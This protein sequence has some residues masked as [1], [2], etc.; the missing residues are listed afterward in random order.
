M[1]KIK[2]A[3]NPISSQLLIGKNTLAQETKIPF[4]KNVIIC[5]ILILLPL[6][7]AMFIYTRRSTGTANQTTTGI[8][9]EKK[10][11]STAST[12]IPLPKRVAMDLLLIGT[13]GSLG[14]LAMSYLELTK[15]T[16]LI[17]TRNM[18]LGM[19]ASFLGFLAA[20]VI[21]A[22]LQRVS[23]DKSNGKT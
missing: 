20:R 22:S 23:V 19:Y 16:R 6:F 4:Y 7:G 9:E 2:T 3:E 21:T 1:Q 14:G 18:K 13:V 11:A 10:E 17:M 12:T 15:R 8:Q 5:I